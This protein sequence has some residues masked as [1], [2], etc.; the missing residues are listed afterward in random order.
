MANDSQGASRW[1]NPTFWALLV[2]AFGNILRVPELQVM[3][4]RGGAF[5]S[6]TAHPLARA[7][8]LPLA[9]L[10]SGSLLGLQRIV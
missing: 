2:L 9:F 6:L 7:A 10:G 5:S 8:L 4:L 3:S 1:G